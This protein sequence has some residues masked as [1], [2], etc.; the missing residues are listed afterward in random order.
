[1]DDV[2]SKA[3][4]AR[5]LELSRSRISQFC[6]AGLPV[7]PDGSLN[8]AEA[9]EWVE[10]NIDPAR[11]GWWGSLRDQRTSASRRPAQ[12]RNTSTPVAVSADVRELPISRTIDGESEIR[13]QAVID[14]VNDL[15]QTK[16]TESF[17]RMALRFGCSL[18]QAF[19]LVEWL[20]WALIFAALPK[21][22]ERQF[23][24]LHGEPNWCR[25]AS[26]LG[27]TADV[28]AWRTWANRLIAEA[29]TE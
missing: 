8:R 21:D 20:N 22:S 1:V 9:V 7:R 13:E 11:G 19:A 17:A 28:L 16:H 15:R 25:I 4:L 12:T 3:E 26:E 27:T 23:I 2:I 24:E 6:K 29:L 14:F 5:E 10:A 18:Q